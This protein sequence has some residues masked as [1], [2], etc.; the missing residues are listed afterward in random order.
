MELVVFRLTPF[1]CFEPRNFLQGV[2]FYRDTAFFSPGSTHYLFFGLL[3]FVLLVV[4]FLLRLDFVLVLIDARLNR[5]RATIG[6][7]KNPVIRKTFLCS[8][9]LLAKSASGKRNNVSGKIKS[10]SAT[11][12]M[13]SF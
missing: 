12:A 9:E 1:F 13:I 11:S 8:A 2:P 7:T 5:M 4:V 3:V 6:A 10:K